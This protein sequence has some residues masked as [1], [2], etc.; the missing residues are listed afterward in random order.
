M[1]SDFSD[2]EFAI[3]I[4]HNFEDG[5]KAP[6]AFLSRNGWLE[7]ACMD[8]VVWPTS[9][10]VCNGVLSFESQMD[11][12]RLAEAILLAWTD[13]NNLSIVLTSFPYAYFE[14]VSCKLRTCG[15]G[16]TV[17]PRYLSLHYWHCH[18]SSVDLLKILWYYYSHCGWHLASNT[19]HLSSIHLER[20]RT[21]EDLVRRLQALRKSNSDALNHAA[22]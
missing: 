21:E 9:L 8:W 7:R 11:D 6:D 15:F 16:F 19:Q 3:L 1:P 17:L 22:A 4:R 2:F 18:T 14:F 13:P 5:R 20:E 12:P 10:S